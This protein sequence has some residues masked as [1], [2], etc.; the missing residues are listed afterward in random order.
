MQL[1][2]QEQQVLMALLLLMLQRTVLLL[3]LFLRLLLQQESAA[4]CRSIQVKL[5]G[6]ATLV[7]KG[8]GVVYTGAGADVAVTPGQGKVAAGQH[9]F[10][11]SQ[12]HTV[13][14]GTCWLS[15]APA[16]RC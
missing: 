7:S 8:K 9:S 2:Q 16:P 6:G 14:S 3:L 11:S 1:Q 4:L 15:R 5:G 13:H 12:T 10:G